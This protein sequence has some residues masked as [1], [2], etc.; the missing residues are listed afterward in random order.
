VNA[1]H[2]T[3]GGIGALL[4]ATLAALL[5][6]YAN[7]SLSDADA[8]LI[9]SACLSAGAGLGHGIYT[10]GVKGVFKVIWAGQKNKETS[11]APPAA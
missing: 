4:G 11:V 3:G 8:A 2:V 10:Y 5:N 9:G 1:G 6:K 7:Y